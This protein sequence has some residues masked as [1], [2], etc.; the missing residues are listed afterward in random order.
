MPHATHQ[1]PLDH[2]QGPAVLLAR[3]LRIL[4]DVVGDSLQQGVEQALIH[5]ASPPSL[6]LHGRFAPGLNRF[7]KL[8]HPL[9]GIRP[10]VEQYVLHPFLQVGGNFL[11]NRQL[12]GVDDGHV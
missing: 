7:R 12:T 8:Q 2:L 3:L 4:V 1:R 9:R 5:R 10:A 11:V 6:V